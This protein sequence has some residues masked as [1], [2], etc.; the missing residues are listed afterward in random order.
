MVVF[1]QIHHLCP[2]LLLYVIQQLALQVWKLIWLIVECLVLLNSHQHHPHC[3]QK[4]NQNHQEDDSFDFF[5]LNYQP[6]F[7]TD[8]FTSSLP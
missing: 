4:H 2:S 7:L 5:V 8:I 6:L 1:G 3:G